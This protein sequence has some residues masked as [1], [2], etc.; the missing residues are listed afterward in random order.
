VALH[1]YRPFSGGSPTAAALP[2]VLPPRL[3]PS[4]RVTDAA[5]V[6]AVLA[7][8]LAGTLGP[9]PRT[10]Q[11]AGRLGISLLAV[12]A[13]WWRR[14]YPLVVLGIACGA[15]LVV[16]A[17][18]GT[19]VAA[20]AV[21][22]ALYTFASRTTRAHAAVAVAAAAGVTL[23]ARL[24]AGAVL[25]DATVTTLVV[26]GA[27]GALGL[28]VGTRRAYVEELARRAD[29]A[30]QER[31]ALARQAA[32]DERARIA[33]ELHDV[34]AHHVSLM[35]V[36]SGALRRRVHAGDASAAVLDSIATTGREALGEMRRLLG[37]LRPD[38]TPAARSPQPGLGD[39]VA[40]AEQVRS[41]GLEVTLAIDGDRR[42]LSPGLELAAYRIVQESLTNVVKHAGARRVQVRIA[43]DDQAV[44]LSIVDDG[45]GPQ[46]PAD[47]G[48]HGLVGMRERVALYG[49]T[50]SVG[51][52][53]GAGFA[54]EARLPSEGAR[55]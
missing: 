51:R 24:I 8:T 40:L 23:A 9:E 42:P 3:R 31:E 49:G 11:L 10:G 41:G 38:A 47:P 14:R 53:A 36:Q 13:L 26:L 30:E 25:P 39:I 34:I 32:V 6:V 45:V 50:L 55:V 54:V 15:S 27:A 43:Y 19:N 18:G 44:A 52:R 48:G 21:A 20:A 37:V 16:V 22:I 7:V 12:A 35:V 46:T 1:A 33:R 17:L 29:R 4:A 5:V 28:Y 2:G